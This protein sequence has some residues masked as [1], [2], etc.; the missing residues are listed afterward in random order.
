MLKW[1]KKLHISNKFLILGYIK[2]GK[3]K[4]LKYI[5]RHVPT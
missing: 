2:N 1:F 3:G 5:L 4:T